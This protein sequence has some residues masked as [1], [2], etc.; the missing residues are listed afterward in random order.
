M[1]EIL[2]QLLGSD[3]LSEETRTEISSKWNEALSAYKTTVTESVTLEV[4]QQLAEQWAEE[5]E[6]LIS[7][8]DAFITKQL[9]EEM[10]ELSAD[11]ER[12]RDLE[13]SYAAKIVEQK[14]TLAK[15]LT[16]EIDSLVDKLDS[17]LELRITEEMKDLRE[18]LEVVKQNQF[19][20]QIYE[21]FASEFMRSQIDESAVTVKLQAA[22]AKLQEA[23]D[24]A[25]KLADKNE[26]LVRESTLNT[27]LA[28]LS[29]KKRE[30]MMFILENVKTAKLESA[31]QQFI[32]R[33]LNESA[34]P[35]DAKPASTTL[36]ESA[37]TVVATGDKTAP[38]A[39]SNSTT[40]PEL[41]R[42]RALAGIRS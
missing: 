28:P 10:S 16:E 30:Q 26:Q 15:T 14:E 13:A 33:V 22:E 29:G 12:F 20:R 5:R 42:L 34:A 3:L 1:D 7:N 31:Y 35:T 24:A 21:A 4:R 18:D 32:G 19:G 25:K 6:T 23:Q 11:Y 17:F 2:Q 9:A 40:N 8:V 39:S 27:L 36:S 37:A 38:A 41:A